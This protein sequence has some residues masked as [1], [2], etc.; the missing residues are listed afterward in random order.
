MNNKPYWYI[1]AWGCMMSSNEE[2]VQ[3]RVELARQEDAPDSA[4]YKGHDG[5]HVLE[6]V[7]GSERRICL[8][9]LVLRLQRGG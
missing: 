6:Q 4:I 3:D 9:N 7:G 8:T 5:W 1:R 2:W